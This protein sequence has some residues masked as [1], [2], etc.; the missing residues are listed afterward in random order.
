MRDKAPKPG[1]VEEGHVYLGGD[2]GNAASW[3]PVQ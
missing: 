2:P 3:Q 1:D